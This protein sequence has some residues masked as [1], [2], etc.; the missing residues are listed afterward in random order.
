MRRLALL[1]LPALLQ[2]QQQPDPRELL[3]RSADAIKKYSSY[4]IHSLSVIETR[5]GTNTR[6]QMPATISVRRPDRMRIDSETDQDSTTVVSDGAHTYIYLEQQKKYIRRAA[7]SSP[8]TALGESGVLKNLPD[9][10]N[11]LKSVQITAE[12]TL[13]IDDQTYECWVVEARYDTIT[14][15][16]QLTIF[17]AVQTSW[18]SK[19]LGLTL[20]NKLTARLLIGTLPEPVVM[21]QATTTVGLSLNADLPDSLF[22]FT[23]P[24]GAT[25]TA[26]W[27]L[28]GITKPDVE[29][30]PAPVLKGAPPT[31]GKVVLLDFWTSWCGPCKRQFPIIEKLN[32]EF[33]GKGLVVLGVNVG[34]DK[35][36]ID[37]VRL[38]YPTL[39]LDA[40]DEA[41]KSLSVHAYPT[42]V[43]IGRT[44]KVALYDIGAKSEASLRAAL[45]KTG[46][47]SPPV[48]P[49]PAS[50]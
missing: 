7:T 11:S 43:L 8:E 2:A 4:Q 15:P 29:G 17:D 20:Q 40:D 41:L 16:G 47:K 39:Q 45:A 26:D 24:P 12:E 30:K 28:P 49:K 25:Q 50:K 21:T 5:G 10:A 22:V 13:E 6:M 48:P 44:G 46:I 33:R 27:T 38:T 1:I 18:I 19:T 34:E 23:P 32:K 36:T 3:Q 37:K 14:V 9:I 35:E 42:L 31:E